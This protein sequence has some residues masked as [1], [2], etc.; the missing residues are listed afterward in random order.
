[1]SH[2]VTQHGLASSLPAES[3]VTPGPAIGGR[4]PGPVAFVPPVSN[5]QLAMLMFIGAEAMLFAGLM[6]AHV[7]LRFSSVVWPPPGQPRLPVGITAANSVVL[8]LSAVAM[9]VA[10]SGAR[11]GRRRVFRNALWITAA[12]GSVFLAV[13][14][15]EWYQLVE[16]GLSLSNVYGS[17]FAALIGLHGLHVLAAVAWLLR[18]LWMAR[19]WQYSTRRHVEADLCGMY[20]MFVCGLW[21]VL[22]GL[23]YLV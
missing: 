8:L 19:R 15:G 14:G 1:M 7:F 9:G 21:I 18:V 20:W 5:A 23:V 16:H 22:F 6:G 12:L 3:E 4:P 13:Q 2:A 10:L 17:T 11:K